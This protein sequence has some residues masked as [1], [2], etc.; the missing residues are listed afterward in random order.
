MLNRRHI[1]K[2][3]FS[4][5]LVYN[6]DGSLHKQTEFLYPAQAAG[7]KGVNLFPTR[8]IETIF[9]ASGRVASVKN[10]ALYNDDVAACFLFKDVTPI[11][12][13]RSGNKKVKE[14]Y[15][16]ADAAK[17]D[18]MLTRGVMFIRRRNLELAGGKVG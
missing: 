7:D 15:A 17:A 10:R 14:L 3:N 18:P 13:G 6:K 12:F 4:S 8:H 5:T 16:L 1:A 11:A 2:P 9:D